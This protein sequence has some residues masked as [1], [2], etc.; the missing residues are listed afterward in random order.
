MFNAVPVERG[1]GSR[2][3]N[4]LYWELGVGPGGRPMADFLIDPPYLVPRGM[5]AARGVTPMVRMEQGQPV[6]HILDRVGLEHYPNLAD[7]VEE[8][9]R[10]GLS[11]RLPSNL[12]ARMVE[13]PGQTE[14]RPLVE[15]LG[16][17]SRLMLIHD[18]AAPIDVLRTN[19]PWRCFNGIENHTPEHY[20]EQVEIWKATAYEGPAPVAC[21]GVCWYDVTEGDPDAP[22][23]GGVWNLLR[24]EYGPFISEDN[25]RLV[26]RNMPS[27][28]YY[29]CRP[30]IEKYADEYRPAIFASVPCSRLAVVDG[31]RAKEI[32][33]EAQRADLRV[34]VTEQ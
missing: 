2:E 27:F 24:P 23:P 16:P 32:A 7:F 22:K 13:I 10:F 3:A 29:A 8:G 15:L 26:R 11:R 30:F 34:E 21:L 6:A 18:R 33:K 31:D 19:K 12:L 20:A 5:I 1:C 17:S 28:H 9:A 14:R 25:P 4:G